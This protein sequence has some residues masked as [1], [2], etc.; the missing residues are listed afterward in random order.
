MSENRPDYDRNLIDVVTLKKYFPIRGGL[1]KRAIGSVKAVDD[2]TFF[3]KRGETLGLVGESGCGKTTVGRAIVMLTPPTAGYVFL[4]TP[5][6]VVK[7]FRTLLDLKNSAREGKFTAGKAVKMLEAVDRLLS[8][9]ACEIRDEKKKNLCKDAG[10]L[11]RQVETLEENMSLGGREDDV[12][13][14]VE[15]AIEEVSQRYCINHK[16]KSEVKR[17]RSR[18]QFVFQDPFSS[19]DPKMLVKDIVAEPLVAQTAPL[20]PNL[21]WMILAFIG[22]VNAIVGAYGLAGGSRGQFTINGRGVSPEEGGRYFLIIGLVLLFLDIAGYVYYRKKPAQTSQMAPG[23]KKGTA[24]KRP[25]RASKEE[26]HNT[27]VKLLE[28]VGLNLEHMYRFPHEFSGGQR[29]RIGIARALS[30]NP[31]FVVLDEPT[32][33]LDVSVQAQILN[34]LNQLQK[35]F[36]LTYLF[37]SHDLST[38]RYMC[39]RVAVMYLGKVVEYSEKHELFNKPTHPYTEALLSVIPVPDPD[40]KRDRIIL[41]GDVPSPANPPSGCRFHTRCPLVIDIC[42]T[43]EPPL[44][45][46]GNEHF[47]ACH[48]R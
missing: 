43:V 13:D 24:T 10:K 32:S 38:I 36:G 3:I 44:T 34:M 46:R 6:E 23:T 28:K 21:S 39:D 41:P 33:A 4:E 18:V 17:L 20:I 42:H 30:V 1:L 35:D 15:Q 40:L 29:Q 31:D 9:Q 26:L 7:D 27:I 19:L 12:L 37:I 16:R 48:V 8:A 22:A 25:R 11:L 5:K 47:V 45:D 14:L 2:V